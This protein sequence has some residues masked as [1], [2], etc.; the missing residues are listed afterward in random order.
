[1]NVNEELTRCKDWIQSALDKGGNTHDFKDIVDG[2]LSGHMQLWPGEKGC[3]VTEIVV[4]PKK[5]V[6]HVF[7]AGGEM[8]TILEMEKDAIKWGK[9][10]GCEA[11]SISGRI[12]WKKVLDEYGWSPQQMVLV[13]EI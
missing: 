2:V 11:A 5:K 3:G 4:Y 1:M 10:Q 13:K 9:S 7:L 12:G 6:L 8:K